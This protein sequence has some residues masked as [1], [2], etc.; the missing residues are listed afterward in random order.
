VVTGITLSRAGPLSLRVG[1]TYS[2]H[3]TVVPESAANQMA[4]WVSSDPAVVRVV[5][6]MAPRFGI[7]GPQS[8]VRLEAVSAG[9]ATITATAMGGGPVERRASL[10]VAVGPALTPAS[11][12]VSPATAYVAT[13]GQRQFFA[14]VGPVGAPQGV[15]WSVEPSGAGSITA[16]GLLTIT[17]AAAGQTVTVRARSLA[18]DAITGAATVTVPEPISVTVA[19]I[20]SQHHG[21]SMMLELLCRE[22]GNEVTSGSASWFEVEPGFP[23]TFVL[24]N[25]AEGGG[26]FQH[27][28][29]PGDYEVRLIFA[30]AGA[31]SWSWD[32]GCVFRIPNINIR[33]GAND[34]SWGTFAYMPPITIVVTEIPDLYR[35]GWGQVGLLVPGTANAIAF[36]GEAYITGSSATFTLRGAVPGLFDVLLLFGDGEIHE[37]YVARARSVGASN[38]MPFGQ[39]ARLPPSITLTV[40]GIPADY[41]GGLGF[42]GLSCAQ[43]GADV[44][45]GWNDAEITGASAVFRFWLVDPGTYDVWLSVDGSARWRESVARARPLA[46]TS[47]MQWGDFVFLE[48]GALLTVT[49]TGIPSQYHG[50]EANLVLTRDSSF[51]DSYWVTSAGTSATFRFRAGP[52][53]YDMHLTFQG[54]GESV[55][56]SLD[57]RQIHPG[58]TSIPFGDFGSPW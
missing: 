50:R 15:S 23:V 51:V 30:P 45:G 31:S 25:W 44:P 10:E 9:T 6:S 40:S 8:A 7:S 14:T 58:T 57:G 1:E 49:V 48:G 20:P 54:V 13:G 19:G 55:G 22:T 21:R 39:F 43:T 28:A 32:E 34:I 4:V 53:V 12:A 29:E 56:R 17:G 3:A 52:G 42:I 26:S 2:L 27:F 18:N 38:N 36:S 11:V 5:E 46:A 24:G 35:G 47:A 41:R 16:G 37:V 33:A